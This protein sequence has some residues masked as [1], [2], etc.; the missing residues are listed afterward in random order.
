MATVL[1]IA[2]FKT[3]AGIAEFLKDISIAL[4]LRK[5]SCKKKII[6]LPSLAV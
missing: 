5:N 6:I 3:R 1:Y 4:E 2:L